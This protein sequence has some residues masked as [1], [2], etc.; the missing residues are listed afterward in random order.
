MAGTRLRLFR[1]GLPVQSS[2]QADLYAA[3]LS[4]RNTDIHLAHGLAITDEERA[5]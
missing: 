2:F 4:I 3:L 5:T 1:A